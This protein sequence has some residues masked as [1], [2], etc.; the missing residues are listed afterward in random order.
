[1]AKF[2]CSIFVFLLGA[3]SAQAQTDTTY[4]IRRFGVDAS[5]TFKKS[6]NP[7]Q[8]G[9]FPPGSFPVYSMTSAQYKRM[10][11]LLINFVAEENNYGSL[12]KNY[13]KQ[14]SLF[15]AKES[16]WIDVTQKEELRARN[17]EDGYYKSLAVNKILDEDLK[18]CE[19]LA[20]GEHKKH[21]R[22]SVVVG[23]AA[24]VA[25]F[26]LGAVAF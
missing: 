5:F 21:K 6:M 8:M 15:K 11:D 25:G 12:L 18:K 9:N 19:Q 20:K 22:K 7:R 16:A 4:T 13:S 2:Y 1:M 26:V 14:D 17:F 10:R 24:A 3:I 23:V